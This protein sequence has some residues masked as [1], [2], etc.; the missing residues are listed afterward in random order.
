MREITTPGQYMTI[1]TKQMHQ[2]SQKCRDD[3]RHNMH[4]HEL[5]SLGIELLMDE[6]VRGVLNGFANF[7]AA[8]QFG[9]DYAMNTGDFPR[10]A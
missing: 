7:L 3:L 9:M 1:L 10:Q 2:Y 4:M 5:D 6:Q 8:H